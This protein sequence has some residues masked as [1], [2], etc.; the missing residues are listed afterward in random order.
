MDPILLAAVAVVAAALVVVMY[1]QRRRLSTLIGRIRSRSDRQSP[2]AAHAEYRAAVADMANRL[3]VAGH[4]APLENLA[5]LPH[6]YT[7]PMP[8]DP[9]DT[10]NPEY[11]RPHQLIPRT[12][13][14]PQVLAPY[15]VPSV[16]LRDLLHGETGVLL[17]GPA[18]SGRTVI[19]ALIAI[20]VAQQTIPND[21][22]G[23]VDALRLPLYVPLSDLPLEPTAGQSVVDPIDP[24]MQATQH[25]LQG[26]AGRHMNAARE[27]FAAGRGVIL[28]DGW[29]ECSP[30]QQRRVIH[31]LAALQTAYPGNKLVVTASVTGS[32]LL[33]ELGLASV[34][35]SPWSARDHRTL[36]QRWVTAWPTIADDAS[37]SQAT[38]DD[39]VTD[40]RTR[41]PLDVTLHTWAAFA[42]DDPDEGRV[43]WYR[44]YVNR[45]A[46]S[47]GLVSGLEQMALRTQVEA[48]EQPA[49][50]AEEVLALLEQAVD[51]LERAPEVEP[52]DFIDEDL[53]TGR[54]LRECADGRIAFSQ[55]VV[56][57]YLAAEALRSESLHPL[58]LEPHP[59][60]RM[61][62]P[63]LA[64][65]RDISAY[66]NRHLER[67]PTLLRG[68]LLELAAWAA[69]APADAPWHR[70]VVGRISEL[71]LQESAYPLLRERALGAILVCRDPAAGDVFR[72]ALR[73]PDRH[74]QMLGILGLGALGDQDNVLMLGQLSERAEMLLEIA[75]TL[76]LGAIESPASLNYL[77]QILLSG[78][79]F[80]R[81]AAAEM[82]AATDLGGEGHDILRD[83]IGEL[84]SATRKAALYGLDRINETWA[85][86]L[87]VTVQH[88]DE[89]WMVRAA[90][91]ILSETPHNQRQAGLPRTAAPPEKATWL[92]EWLEPHGEQP[93]H[94]AEG[95]NQLLRALQEG[96]DTTC[97]AAVETAGVL[98]I[99]EAIKPLYAALN[100]SHPEIRDSAFRALGAI[101]RASDQAL[102]TPS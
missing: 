77:I 39:C 33:S 49:L 91:G 22:D 99:V 9:L 64:Q 13:D 5:V 78:S 25:L 46:P 71:F 88:E 23:L 52:Q 1:L 63:F 36:V 70:H 95:I 2:H 69:D 16:R 57:A 98:G 62:M 24:L 42:G 81:R 38:I 30:P 86:E 48:P 59:A 7:P 76:A 32:G 41:S 19:L 60:T 72:D 56:A 4:L 79:G 93:S 73:S 90:A 89:Q 35:V 65:L 10:D 18:G 51:N 97:L 3:H 96:D 101:S 28:L 55:P 43:G 82:L 85:K 68:E 15:Y 11:D 26:I 84:D 75:A 21:P 27:E 67:Q 83:A 44:A 31:W 53:H 20:A 66:A 47:A 50:P 102:P 6:F 12:P 74:L 40:N 34:Y 94:G 17:M 80:A 37:P 29:D 14:W 100:N 54:L 45:V 87:I 92:A 8:F 61:V 58:L